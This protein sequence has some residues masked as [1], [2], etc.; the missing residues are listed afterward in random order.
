MKSYRLFSVSPLTDFWY[1]NYSDDSDG[2]T[3]AVQA[4]GLTVKIKLPDPSTPVKTP[5]EPKSESSAEKKRPGRPRKK[6]PKQPKIQKPRGRPPKCPDARKQKQLVAT[7]AH[8][9]EIQDQLKRQLEEP[10]KTK[11][12]P[13]VDSSSDS[14]S[15]DDD[16]PPPLP[17]PK[18]VSIPRPKGFSI[19]KKNYFNSDPF[20]VYWKIEMNEE[21]RT[22][23]IVEWVWKNKYHF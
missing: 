14:S 11:S 1:Q 15:S 5:K 7:K 18:P 19:H 9:E 2:E 17:P 8:L 12:Q 13:I 21:K 20:T 10:K 23:I 3:P 16:I 6:S 4:D 22:K